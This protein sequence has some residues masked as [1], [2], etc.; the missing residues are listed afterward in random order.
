MR[1]KTACR[2]WILL[3]CMAIGLQGCDQAS[4]RPCLVSGKVTFDG[5]PL[6]TGSILFFQI[7][8]SIGPD[9]GKI[10]DGRYQIHTTPGLKRVEIQAT[11][12]RPD[13]K[14][15]LGEQGAEQTYIPERFNAASTLTADVRQDAAN[16]FD[17][18]LHS[19]QP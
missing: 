13:V 5:Q 3:C 18:T 12:F 15:P 7:D 17:F 2:I 9:G 16:Q 8:S 14:G 11:R 4:V 6:K 19:D 10:V 1:E